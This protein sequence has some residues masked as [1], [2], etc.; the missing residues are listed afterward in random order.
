MS[1][2]LP[3]VF[4]LSDKL[5]GSSY[6]VCLSALPRNRGHCVQLIAQVTWAYDV[7]THP[8]IAA[9]PGAEGFHAL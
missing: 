6:T 4:F 5:V 8:V 7:P 9:R 1:A 3:V 2:F